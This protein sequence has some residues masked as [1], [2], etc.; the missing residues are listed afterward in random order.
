VVA[1]W[2]RSCP[3]FFRIWPKAMQRP[4]IQDMDYGKFDSW[5]REMDHPK[6]ARINAESPTMTSP[7]GVL[8]VFSEWNIIPARRSRVGEDWLASLI[9]YFGSLW[10]R[11]HIDS[12]LRLYVP[13]FVSTAYGRPTSRPRAMSYLS[14]SNSFKIVWPTT[15]K[16]EFS[17]LP[18]YGEYF[19]HKTRRIED[20]V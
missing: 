14:S 3:W 15:Q 1:P 7:T 17:A 19:R 18:P 6:R 16:M 10:Q 13:D 4:W 8:F 12:W 20:I 2:P 11:F 5:F 9:L